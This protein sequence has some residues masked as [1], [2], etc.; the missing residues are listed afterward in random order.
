MGRSGV[1]SILRTFRSHAGNVVV[2][3]FQVALAVAVICNALFIATSRYGH[4]NQPSGLNESGLVSIL[5]SST[6]Q[7]GAGAGQG[8]YVD[9]DVRALQQLPGVRK[10]TETFS[11][12]LSGSTIGGGVATTSPSDEQRPV[13]YFFADTQALS[14]LGVRLLAGRN[15][16]AEEVAPSASLPQS[17]GPVIITEALAG[18]LYSSPDQALG[19]ALFL[20]GGSFANTIVGVVDRMEI[21]SVH[22]EETLANWYTVLVPVRYAGDRANYVL[23]VEPGKEQAVQAKALAA[24]YQIDAERVIDPTDVKTFSQLRA[25]MFDEDIATAR[26]MLGIVLILLVVT[27]F[28]LYGLIS[29]WIRRRNRQIG[30]RRALGATK[31]DILVYF[32]V[33]NLLIC[34]FAG[35]LGCIAALYISTQFMQMFA[36][37]RLPIM[38]LLWGELA[39]I[40]VSQVATF[41][42]AIGASKLP[43]AAIIR[44]A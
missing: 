42:P 32:H 27:A 6:K 20:N 16:T 31:R 7:T 1:G 18:R 19:K 14:T 44:R 29:S 36:T 11:L 3:A 9:A 41:V 28:G 12:P 15:F 17:A 35:I 40:V 22:K 23:Q 4:V 33:E 24:L 8:A 39:V 2:I 25:D 26:I 5:S 30:I 38:Y 34:V 13:S 43:P 21:P 10:V 37:E